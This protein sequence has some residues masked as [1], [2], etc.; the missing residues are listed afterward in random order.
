MTDLLEVMPLPL[1]RTMVDEKVEMLKKRAEEQKE[2]AD[3]YN[4]NK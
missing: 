1:M 4:G 3:K 2:M